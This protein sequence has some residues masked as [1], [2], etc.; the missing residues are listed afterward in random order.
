MSHSLPVSLVPLHFRYDGA[1]VVPEDRV[2]DRL[3][4][5]RQW[6]T[7]AVGRF[8]AIVPASED[9]SFRRYFRIIYPDRTLIVMDAPPAMESLGAWLRVRALLEERGIHVPALIRAEPRL[10]FV[11]MEDLGSET[12]EAARRK[13]ASPDV[14]FDHAWETLVCI[15]QMQVPDDWPCY[16]PARLREEMELFWVWLVG[17][18]LALN[19]DRLIRERFE[20]VMEAL[21]ERAWAQPRVFVHRDYHSRN[22]LV[23]AGKYPGVIDFQDALMGPV[24][25]DAVSLLRD[26]YVE[27]PAHQVEGWLWDY[28]KR[29]GKSGVPVPPWENWLVDFDWMGV[30]RHLKAAGIFARL[31]HRDGKPG[32]LPEIPRTL[33]YVIRVGESYP[34]LEILGEWIRDKILPATLASP[35]RSR[36]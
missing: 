22:L 17:E 15:Q 1:P 35:S 30:Q 9:A 8:E 7:A 33:G 13:G 31:S 14:L 27:W 32:Y 10:G 36:G 11:V 12:Y 3:T 2:L 4:E 21:V 18:H 6:V 19:R 20:N 34:E 26:C 24:S 16:D 29:A 5:L 28:H 23:A 25:Y